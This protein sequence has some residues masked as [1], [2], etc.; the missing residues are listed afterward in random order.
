[1]VFY[2]KTST[3]R[4]QLDLFEWDRERELRRCNQAAR[5][6]ARKFGLPIHH[7]VT[8]ARLAGIEGEARPMTRPKLRA[9]IERLPTIELKASEPTNNAR[10][11]ARR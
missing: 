4:N 11:E 2:S 9:W 5:R 6:T 10:D 3:S 8:I 1:M 7:A